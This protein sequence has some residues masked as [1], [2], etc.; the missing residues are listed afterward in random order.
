ML[1]PGARCALEHGG[2][3]PV[4]VAADA[5]LGQAIPR[6]GRAGFW[7]AGQACVSVQRIFCARASSI[8]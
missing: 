4:I 2:V 6:L 1:A 8:R 7:H 5:D 3:A